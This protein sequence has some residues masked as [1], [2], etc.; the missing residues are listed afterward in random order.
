M[1]AS[2]CEV[3]THGHTLMHAN[4]LKPQNFKSVNNI[5][6]RVTGRSVY[7]SDDG[8]THASHSFARLSFGAKEKI[9]RTKTYSIGIGATE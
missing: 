4:V 1:H 5:A 7:R 2:S 6:N 8:D 9:Y 3:C